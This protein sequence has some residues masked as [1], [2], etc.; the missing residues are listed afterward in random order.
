MLGES[1][2]DV[3]DVVVG[4]Q[5]CRYSLTYISSSHLSCITPPSASSV[6]GPVMVTTLS[7]GECTRTMLFLA[8]C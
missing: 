8:Q 7:G 1:L 6:T 3:L 5:S 4:G 2:A